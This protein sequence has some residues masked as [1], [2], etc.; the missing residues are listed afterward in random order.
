ME[1]RSSAPVPGRAPEAIAEPPAAEDFGRVHATHRGFYH[2]LATAYLQFSDDAEEAV[3]EGFL[4]AWRFRGQFRGQCALSSW[5]AA[6]VRRECQDRLRRNRARKSLREVAL[7]EWHDPGAEN[8][9]HETLR[10]ADQRAVVLR[11]LVRLRPSERRYI[12]SV[13]AGEELD[14]RLPA[15]KAARHRAVLRLRQMLAQRRSKTVSV[16]A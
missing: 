16:A 12:G 1:K 9:A 7:L 8:P 3:Q 6:I 4:K 15:N 14:M 10:Q 11:L 2:K 5:V 13:L